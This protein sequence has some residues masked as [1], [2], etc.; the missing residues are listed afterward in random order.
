MASP[1]QFGI[2]FDLDG[3]LIDSH[4]QHEQAWFHLAE[5]IDK[6]LTPAQFTESFGMRNETCI[7]DVF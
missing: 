1:S 2:V 6:P 3:V 7:P 5:E 4:D